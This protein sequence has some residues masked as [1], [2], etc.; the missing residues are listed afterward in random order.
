MKKL[1][2]YLAVFA[3]AIVSVLMLNTTE[4]QATTFEDI[5]VYTVDDMTNFDQ[6]IG[7]SW[8]KQWSLNSDAGV[9]KQVYYG[10]FTLAQDSIVRIKLYTMDEEAFAADDFFR[11][12]G[13]SAMVA[14]MV[15]NNIQYGEGD[16]WVILKAG[17]YYAECGTEKYMKSTSNH[18]TKVLIGAVPLSK[19]VKVEQI[20]SA[21][22]TKMT[23]KL[24]PYYA[25]EFSVKRWKEGKLESVSTYGSTDIDASNA[26]TVTKNGW[27]SVTMKA[28]STVAWNQEVEYTIHVKVSGIGAGAKKGVT[29]KVNNL[30]YKVVKTGFDGKGTVAVTGIVKQK[31]SVTIPKT[32]KIKGH[33]YKIVKIASKAFY[34]KSKIKNITIKATTITSIGKNAI[35]GINKKAKIYVPKSKYTKYKKMLTAK[36]GFAKKT[37]KIKKK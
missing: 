20:A 26:F 16:D 24:T 11:L 1:A 27:Y 25:N 13:T 30:K 9:T 22:R 12:Y 10:K 17:T 5:K 2:S 14:P 18:V 23:V 31:A 19:A 37:M 32:V 4:I 3:M 28:K 6:T 15:E 7:L 8:Q 36:T 35:K 29:Y 34:K 33:E 21:D